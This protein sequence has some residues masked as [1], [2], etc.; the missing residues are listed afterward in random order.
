MQVKR[1]IKKK[2]ANRQKRFVRS[3]YYP[4][5]GGDNII[6]SGEGWIEFDFRNHIQLMELLFPSQAELR[7]SCCSCVSSNCRPSGRQCGLCSGSVCLSCLRCCDSCQS[8]S[9]SSCAAVRRC[10]GCF[11]LF[12]GSCARPAPGSGCVCLGCSR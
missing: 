4:V 7:T 12:C 9:C 2:G 11:Q 10:D 1:K 3:Q 5:M 6:F 8:T